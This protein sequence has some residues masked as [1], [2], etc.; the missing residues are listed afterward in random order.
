MATDLNAQK[1]AL[2]SQIRVVVKNIPPATRAAA[3]AQVCARL[4]TQAFWKNAAAIL[5]FAPLPD[6]VD[7]WPLLEEALAAGKTV[8]LPRF[9]QTSQSYVAGR[10]KNLRSEIVTGKLGIRE[11][12]AHCLEIPST[13]L[14]LVL[15]PGVAFDSQGRRLGRGK[16][17]YDR[18]LRDVRGVKCGIGFEEQIVNEVPT[19]PRDARLDFILT[20]TRCVFPAGE[21]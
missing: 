13:Q 16:G 11:P 6:E 7:I 18:L 17:Y 20:P 21:L 10:V 12:D 2:R 9:N 4:K 19:G 8:A 14:D 1:A 5:F 15:T 3:S